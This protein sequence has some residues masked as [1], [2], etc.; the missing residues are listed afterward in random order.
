MERGDGV[1]AEELGFS[2]RDGEVAGDF[3]SISAVQI[4]FALEGSILFIPDGSARNKDLGSGISRDVIPYSGILLSVVNSILT[5]RSAAPSPTVA[6]P[7][8]RRSLSFVVVALEGAL[9]GEAKARRLAKDLEPGLE[10]AGAPRDGLFRAFRRKARCFINGRRAE[11][12]IC[13]VGSR[14]ARPPG[15]REPYVARGLRGNRYGEP[16][17]DRHLPR[18]RG[19]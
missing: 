18:D 12:R 6:F 2:A 19:I 1:I 15:R 8:A 11:R 16:R 14:R 10:G 4:L 17:D 9:T 3:Y 5:R 13:S 7:L